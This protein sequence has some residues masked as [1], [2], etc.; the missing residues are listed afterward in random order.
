MGVGSFLFGGMGQSPNPKKA[1]LSDRDF[2]IHNI[3]GSLGAVNDRQAPQAGNTTISP[4]MTGQASQLNTAQADAARAQQQQLAGYYN[5]VITGQ[6]AG[7]GELAA[8][9]QAVRAAAA[10]HAM[11]ASARGS[12]AALAARG[13]ARNVADIGAGA[14]G[15]AQQAAMQDQAQ[16][17]GQMNQLTGTMRGQ[18]ID[19]AGQNA[20]LKQ[21]MNLSN[22]NA[23][24]QQIFQQAGLN[25]ATSL[26]N[27]QARLQTMGLN[28][29]AALGYLA[30]L[31][32]VNAAEMQARMAQEQ[33]KLGQQGFMGD[34]LSAGGTLGAAYL[35]RPGGG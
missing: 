22:L 6:Q 25:Q 35:G 2:I 13:A 18:D 9:R 4:V 31:Y 5:N 15:A 14:A 21:N 3:Q 19:V 20:Q 23:Q 11:A 17:A 10:Q 32:G 16:A 26:A 8:Q 33:A 12:N 28:D 30:Q 24:N 34:L 27:M 1:Q 7:A 29:Q